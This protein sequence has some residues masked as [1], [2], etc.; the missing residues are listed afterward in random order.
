M[1]RMVEAVPD[2]VWHEQQHFT[3]YSP[4]QANVLMS[5]MACDTN[6]LIGG[7]DDSF[8]HKYKTVI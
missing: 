1:E 7:Q 8:L 5:R 3:T 2:V 6:R 4:W